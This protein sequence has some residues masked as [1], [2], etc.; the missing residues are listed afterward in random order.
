MAIPRRLIALA[1]LVVIG[2]GAWTLWPAPA[3]EPWLG[4]VEGETLYF[5]APVAGTLARRDVERG[6]EV[7]PGQS[8]FTLDPRSVDAAVA[9]SAAQVANA[10]AQAADL[11]DPRQRAPEIDQA[12]AAEASARAQLARAEADFERFSALAAKGFASRT[13]L[14]AA[15]EARDVAAAAIRQAQAQQSAGRMTAGRIEQQRAAQAGVAG[16]QASLRAQQRQRQEIAPVSPVAGQVEQVY[17]NPGEWV[18]AN[19]PVVSVIPA[20]R[21]KIRFFVGQDR[22]AA[23][24]PGNPVTFTCD[25]CSQPRTATIRYI[26]PRA[27][28]T[29]PVIYSEHARAKL[30]FMVEA[31]LPADQPLPLG[32]PVAV[33]P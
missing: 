21:R 30:V 1:G 18:A 28:F 5:A 7:H 17:Y 6:A 25:G 33:Q 29:P 20:D 8:L 4:Y 26:A 19:Q 10:S 13:Q 31:A 32:L 27:E 16:A 24:H 9:A 15:R 12:R 11:T 22:V 3:T 14:D 2:A 23:L